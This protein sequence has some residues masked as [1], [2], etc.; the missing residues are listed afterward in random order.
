MK[1]L[2]K[3]IANQQAV[4]MNDTPHLGSFIRLNP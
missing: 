3:K 1:Q 4:K 2:P